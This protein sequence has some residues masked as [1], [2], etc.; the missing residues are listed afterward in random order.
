MIEIGIAPVKPAEFVDLPA[1]ASSPPAPPRSPREL[2]PTTERGARRCQPRNRVRLR[3]PPRPGRQGGRSASSASARGSTRRRRS[4]STSRSTRTASPIIRKVPGAL[5]WSNITLKRGV[6]ESLE[7]WKWRKQVIEEG[8]DSARV[9]GYIELLDYNGTPDRD[10]QVH[11]GLAGQV[12]GRQLRRRR[13]T[14]SRW[15]SSRS[16]TRDSRSSSGE[17]AGDAAMRTEFAF[18]LPRGWVDAAGERHRE[19]RMRLATARDEIE[20]LRDPAV[21]AE[22][23]VPRRAPARPRRHAASGPVTDVTPEM[24]EGLFAADFDHLQRLYERLNTDGEAVGAISCPSCAPRLRGRPD[25]DRGRPPGGTTRPS[26]EDCSRRRPA[27]PT[28]STGRS[29]RSSTWSTVT[30]GGSSTR[31][32]G[33][34][35]PAA[36]RRGEHLRHRRRLAPGGGPARRARRVPADRGAAGHRRPDHRADRVGAAHARGA[37]PPRSASHRAAPWWRARRAPRPRRPRPARPAR[38]RA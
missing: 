13:A 24:I 15:R 18:T 16:A 11:P 10:V 20:P 3:L 17:P 1:S 35:R 36:R 37:R 32:R 34:R 27:S 22:R 29:T 8:P 33:S 23:G 31:R 12:H 38:P 26:P 28:T 19:G 9:D 2:P 6:D 14:T 4:S 30:G 21:R 7:L 25:R 5:K